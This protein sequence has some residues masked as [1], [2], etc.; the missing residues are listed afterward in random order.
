MEVYRDNRIKKTLII[1]LYLYVPICRITFFPKYVQKNFWNSN[2]LSFKDKFN[3]TTTFVIFFSL[4][5]SFINYNAYPMFKDELITILHKLKKYWEGNTPNL[6]WVQHSLDTKI[7]Y[8]KIRN[9]QTNISYQY[10]HKTL[11][12]NTT[13]MQLL[14]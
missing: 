5:F 9:V 7:R 11:Q 12:Q 6:F 3:Y 10:R 13:N 14:E 4:Q 2:V 1:Y 8:H